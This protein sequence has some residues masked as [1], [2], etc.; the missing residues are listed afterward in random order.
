MAAARRALPVV[1]DVRALGVNAPLR[2]F[3]ELSKRAGG[4][5]LVFGRLLARAKVRRFQPPLRLPGTDAVPDAAVAR[6]VEAAERVAAGAVRL[7][8]RDV[9]IGDPPAWDSLIEA[10][11]TWPSAP[12]WTIDIRSDARSGDVKWTWE[13]GRLR[14]VAALARAAA[15]APERDDLGETLRRQVRSWLEQNPPET[16]V[17]WYSNL[18]I[19]L[20]AVVWAEVLERA[21]HLLGDDLVSGLDDHLA[22][23]LRHLLADLPYTLSTM[24]NN[25]LLGDALGLRILQRGFA[26]GRPRHSPVAA[27][28]HRMFEAQAARHFHDD[29]S[30]IEDSMSYHR[31]VL[32]MLIVE[33]LLEPSAT[34]RPALAG[35]AQLLARLG[36]LEGPVPQYGD[37]DEG[38]VLATTQDPHDLR[39]TVRCAFAVA[40]SGAPARWRDE[41]DECAWYVPEGT[42]VDPEPSERDG[43]DVGGG[44][45]RAQRGDVVV[46]LKAGSK[47]SHGHADLLS[48]PILWNGA[49]V[50]G[51]PGT[52][53][54]NGPIEQRNYFRTA[55]AH[56]VLR[57]GDVDQ[58]GPHR[59]FRW[60]RTARG[61]VGDPVETG[62]WLVLW[63]AHDAYRF[64]EPARRVARAVLVRAGAVVVADW[65]EGAPTEVAVSLPLG[66]TATW[67]SDESTIGVGDDGA[68][69]LRAAA[70]PSAVRGSTAPYDGWWS[71][72]YGTAVPSTRLELRTSAGGPLWWS[73][74]DIDRGS[75]AADGD[76]LV[77]GGLRIGVAFAPGPVRLRVECDQVHGRSVTL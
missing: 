13:L 3:Y 62:G 5:S 64:L 35:S 21:P 4:H 73:V 26:H 71:P 55:V 49:W 48:T 28:S 52:G 30:M 18:E 50:V 40:G 8:G 2:A 39:G 67:R 9:E 42:P 32:E 76:D 58:L 47:P 37:W 25:H 45:A 31:F 15:A 57:V 20:R 75:I 60:E 36:A 51:D 41:H 63:G 29:G 17:H 24:R 72:T 66:P 33:R 65:L 43:H 7:F 77:V 38:R 56:N 11:G 53:T 14:H 69:R 23:C 54:Y 34:P 22:R 16:G 44:T 61:V 59:A 46:W 70:T 10:S 1:K 27:L 6:A 68:L 74:E 19:A 12:W